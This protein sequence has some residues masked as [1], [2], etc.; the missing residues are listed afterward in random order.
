MLFNKKKSTFLPVSKAVRSTEIISL[1]NLPNINKGLAYSS[2]K[3]LLKHMKSFLQGKGTRCRLNNGSCISCAFNLEVI[4]F[5]ERYLS[6]I[7][8]RKE[9]TVRYSQTKRVN[10]TNR[11]QDKH[12]QRELVVL[13]LV[14]FTG[15]GGGLVGW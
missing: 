5:I 14:I 2:W 4:L 3:A 7:I 1:R 6:Q 11:S 12:S 9:K 15:A 13:L 8:I 10:E